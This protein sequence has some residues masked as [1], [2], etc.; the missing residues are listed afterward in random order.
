MRHDMLGPEDTSSSVMF[1]SLCGPGILVVPPSKITTH[2]HPPS[3][4]V[5]SPPSRGAAYF[6]ELR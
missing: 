6:A 1:E 3:I 4:R 5:T 2:D